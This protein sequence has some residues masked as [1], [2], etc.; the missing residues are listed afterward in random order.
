[1]TRHSPRMT[2]PP[3]GRSL[4]GGTNPSALG[5]A[6]HQR[7]NEKRRFHFIRSLGLGTSLRAALHFPTCGWSE[8]TV[9][10][11]M[12]AVCWV[13][14]LCIFLDPTCETKGDHWV[15]FAYWRHRLFVLLGKWWFLWPF[16]LSA[17]A[18]C[19]PVACTAQ[20]QSSCPGLF[21]RA[22]SRLNWRRFLTHYQEH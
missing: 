10:T 15:T 17:Q 19:P 22:G 6:F 16:R 1:M 4:L 3:P 12:C 13:E 9:V 21:R 20:W 7:G 18:L 5:P 2:P 8:K 11:P 14:S